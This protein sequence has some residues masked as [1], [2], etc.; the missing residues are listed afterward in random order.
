MP[1][2]TKHL[3]K[4]VLRQLES[5]QEYLGSA[6]QFRRRLLSAETDTDDE[7]ER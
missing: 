6:E 3:S 5:P 7:K 2:V 4:A 1:Q